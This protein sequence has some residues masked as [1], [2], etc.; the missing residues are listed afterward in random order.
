MD[1]NTYR[2]TGLTLNGGDLRCPA[3]AAVIGSND[4]N[5]NRCLHWT[6]VTGSTG[7]AG[8]DGT[9]TASRLLTASANATIVGQFQRNLSYSAAATGAAIT[10]TRTAFTSV[11]NIVTTAPTITLPSVA[12]SAAVMGGVGNTAKILIANA[13][14]LA[15]N[16]VSPAA[17]I[18]FV[19]SGAL[20][21]NRVYF[22]LFVVCET[23][24]T[25]YKYYQT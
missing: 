23:A 10:L 13:G 22:E 15:I 2:G 11:V 5:F 14:A 19:P 4:L 25:V 17:G 8:T 1:L 16:V 21:T 9:F 18:V 7:G 24:N 12:E 3:S 6:P 20:P